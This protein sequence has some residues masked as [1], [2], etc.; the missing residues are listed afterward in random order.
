MGNNTFASETVGVIGCLGLIEAIH[1]C[2]SITLND[3]DYAASIE[4]NSAS[5]LNDDD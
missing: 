3:K 2:C 4:V 5:C 1:R